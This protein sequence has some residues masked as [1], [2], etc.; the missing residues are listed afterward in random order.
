MGSNLNYPS[1][2]TK[3]AGFWCKRWPQTSWCLLCD[4]KGWSRSYFVV[5][6]QGEPWIH[7][8]GSAISIPAPLC[9]TRGSWPGHLDTYLLVPMSVWVSECER[10][11]SIGEWVWVDKINLLKDF[12]NKYPLPLSWDLMQ[13]FFTLCYSNLQLYKW[14]VIHVEN[15]IISPPQT[16]G[17]RFS[18]LDLTVVFIPRCD[19]ITNGMPLYL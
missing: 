18:W 1:W 15:H 12:V 10:I 5:L 7:I 2:R 17:Q 8:E 16:E 19:I 14:S 11:K 9:Q 13:N 3:Q 4:M 6:S